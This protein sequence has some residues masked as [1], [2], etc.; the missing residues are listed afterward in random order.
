[1]IVRNK[2]TDVYEGLS[3]RET[4]VHTKPY[5]PVDVKR[6]RPCWGSGVGRDVRTL[7]RG[8]WDAVPVASGG[9]VV[10]LQVFEP[11]LVVGIFA[12]Y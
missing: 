5:T 1:M 11:V 2:S 7:G 8:P 9:V 4:I 6:Y 3:G 10:Q 12:P